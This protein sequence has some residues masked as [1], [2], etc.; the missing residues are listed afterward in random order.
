MIPMAIR[1]VI[2]LYVI[3]TYIYICVRTR[4]SFVNQ[5]NIIS[6][7]CFTRA[8]FGDLSYIRSY[9]IL[10]DTVYM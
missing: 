8:R 10:Y 4:A 6:R 2:T 9:F 1:Y 5:F 3:C 7:S